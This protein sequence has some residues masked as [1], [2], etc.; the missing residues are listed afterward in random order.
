M[1]ITLLQI[2]YG[3]TSIV[4]LVA[5]W[6][7]NLQIEEGG[8]ANF[9][10]D[11][12]VNSASSSIANDLFVVVFTYL[13]WSSLEIKRLGMSLRLGVLWGIA[14]AVLTLVIAAACGVPLFM[15]MRE[16]RLA[17]LAE[18]QSTDNSA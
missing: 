7:F 1:K 9:I 6:Y 8:F 16:R 13:V 15:L 3:T 12:Y 10:S 17:K 5:T 18:A 14:N 2:V 4:G 11:L